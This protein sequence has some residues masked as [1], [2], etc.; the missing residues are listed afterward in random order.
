MM[1]SVIDADLPEITFVPAEGIDYQLDYLGFVDGQEAWRWQ[2]CGPTFSDEYSSD[3]AFNSQATAI[4]DATTVLIAAFNEPIDL[5][6]LEAK[7]TGIDIQLPGASPYQSGVH[8]TLFTYEEREGVYWQGLCQ[9]P[10]EGDR[11][12]SEDDF[13]DCQSNKGH[14]DAKCAVADAIYCFHRRR[15]LSSVEV[16]SLCNELSLPIEQILAERFVSLAVSRSLEGDSAKADL[17][18]MSLRD[19]QEAIIDCI[20]V[21]VFVANC[22]GWNNVAFTQLDGT[23][24]TSA[25]RYQEGFGVILQIEAEDWSKWLEGYAVV[26]D[27]EPR[28]ALV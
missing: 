3:R 18:A 2:S 21:P 12:W 17:E 19:K 10:G 28:Y 22:Y 1:T 11:W 15:G 14:A 6:D 24:F 5:S 7:A 20:D 13:S 27:I 26:E 23:T 8:F 16:L 25:E 9:E 4:D